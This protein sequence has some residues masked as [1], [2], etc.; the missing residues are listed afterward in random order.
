MIETLKEI[1]RIADEFPS[2]AK[3]VHKVGIEPEPVLDAVR[4]GYQLIAYSAD[5]HFLGVACRRGLESIRAGLAEAVAGRSH[6]GGVLN[7]Q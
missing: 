5:M 1:N 2:I 4:N 3:G 7:E 6:G